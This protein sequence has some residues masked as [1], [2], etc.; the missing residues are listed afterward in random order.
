MS[1]CSRFVGREPPIALHRIE[2][3]EIHMLQQAKKSDR[4]CHPI[5]ITMRSQNLSILG[6]VAMRLS[7][8]PTIYI[9]YT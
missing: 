5:A 4:R 7:L 9:S 2:H 8:T 3:K 6:H 1:F